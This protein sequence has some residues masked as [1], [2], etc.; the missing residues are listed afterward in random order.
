MLTREAVAEGEEEK[1]P[2]GRN[3]GDEQSGKL[4]KGNDDGRDG[5]GLNNE[6]QSPAVK[7]PK[8]RSE[9]LAQKNILPSS[10]RR[11]SS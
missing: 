2:G 6:K 8:Q 5:A 7:E 9:G 3:P 4:G 1:N 10:K 11:E